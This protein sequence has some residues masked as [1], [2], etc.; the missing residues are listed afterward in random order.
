MSGL[1]DGSISR[2]AGSKHLRRLITNIKF[3]RNNSLMG[4]T[5]LNGRAIESLASN[6]GWNGI[7][8]EFS[9]DIY[10]YIYLNVWDK[11]DH[12][13]NCYPFD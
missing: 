7:Q 9:M 4:I 12:G 8:P 10:I 11:I 3:I 5:I 1:V 13:I 6:L 2:L